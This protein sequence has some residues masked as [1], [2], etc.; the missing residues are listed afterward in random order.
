MDAG[1]LRKLAALEERH[2]WYAERRHLLK[3]TVAALPPGRAL[4]VGAAAGGN[5]SVL[6]RLGWTTVAVDL[7]A[8]GAGLGQERGVRIA[9]ASA[10]ELPFADKAFDLV[11][12]MDIWEHIDNDAAAASETRRVLRSGGKA[13]VT[14]PSDMALWSAHDVAVGHVRR[15]DRRELIH[16]LSCAGLTVEK[17]TSWNVLLRPVVAW[18]R[19]KR[20]EGSDLEVLPSWINMGLRAMVATERLLPTGRLSGVSLVALATRLP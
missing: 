4:D 19:S 13:F 15:Y 9:R 14:V 1:E 3:R 12:A 11:M 10:T 16:L 17:V 8:T 5:T 18:R 7:S 20:A 2:W 6:T